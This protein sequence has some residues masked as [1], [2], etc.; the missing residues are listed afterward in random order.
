MR[1]FRILNN[2]LKDAFKSVFRN[3][4]LSVASIT[5]STITLILVGI[6]I[7][8]MANVNAFTKDLK[9]E[10]TIVVFL[11]RGTT[12]EQANLIKTQIEAIDN[13][14][15]NNITFYSNEDV[16]NDMQLKYDVFDSIMNKWTLE[17]NFLQHEFEV[18][19]LDVNEIKKTSEEIGKLEMV[20]VTKYGEEMVDQLVLVFD[21]VEKISIIIVASL[22][23]VTAF[24]ISNTIKL[25]IYS[26]KTEIEIMRLIGTSNSVIRLP[27]VFEGLFLGIIGAII[28]IILVVY[29]YTI[30]YDKLGGYLFSKIITM[31]NPGGFII[32]VALVILGIAALV[33]MVG[34]YRAVRKYLKI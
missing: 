22:I 2:S 14:D 27:F 23:V 9:E 7:I 24:L 33:G 4:S 5:C 25:T 31:I 3:F 10:L 1:I 21:A 6:A 32:Y 17:D 28:P 11:K 13:I 19:V 8:L 34:S 18:K 26:R 15:K 20:D 30:A 29:G 16:K 12:I